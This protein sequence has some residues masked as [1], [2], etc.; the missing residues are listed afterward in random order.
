M[1]KFNV[2]MIKAVKVVFRQKIFEEDFPEKGM[3]AWLTGIE[4]DEVY[5]DDNEYCYTLYFDFSDFEAKNEKYLREV[6]YPNVHTKD[7]PHKTL[8]TAREAGMYSN[9]YSVCYGERGGP[10]SDGSLPGLD[11]YLMYVVEEGKA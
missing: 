2:N 11:D 3:T 1:S 8:Y 9:K 6:Y 4:L 5:E 10:Q 7:L